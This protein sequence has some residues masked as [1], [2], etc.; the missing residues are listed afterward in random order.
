MLTKPFSFYHTC[1]HKLNYRSTSMQT[2]YTFHCAISIWLNYLTPT[3]FLAYKVNLLSSCMIIIHLTQVNV[4]ESMGN[5]CSCMQFI[6]SLIF[7]L[8]FT[9]GSVYIISTASH[10]IIRIRYYKLG[11]SNHWNG[12]WNGTTEWK[13]EWNSGHTQTLERK[14]RVWLRKTIS[15][16]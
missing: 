9:W 10:M 7:L 14:T 16:V 3:E 13:M 4:L 2:M 8:Q 12:I 6:K 11:V 5:S 1:L 15:I